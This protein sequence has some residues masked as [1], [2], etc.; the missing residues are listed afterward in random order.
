MDPKG[1]RF[2]QQGVRR[3]YLD[4]FEGDTQSAISTQLPASASQAGA[5]NQS[6]AA[7]SPNAFER[8][9]ELNSAEAKGEKQCRKR[10]AMTFDTGAAATA[11]PL[12][13]EG[14]HTEADGSSCRAA[15]GDVVEDEG[16]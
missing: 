3:G 15:T 16:G 9:L 2:Q 4:N 14:E 10:I 6:P 1:Q 8:V 5:C 13:Q 7:L 11:F 12:E